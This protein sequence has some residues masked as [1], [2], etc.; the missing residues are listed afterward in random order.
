MNITKK[1]GKKCD[2]FEYFIVMVFKCYNSVDKEVLEESPQATVGSSHHVVKDI[3]GG[4]CLRSS[5]H[6]LFLQQHR[7]SR[8]R[9]HE[10]DSSATDTL[11]TLSG[12]ERI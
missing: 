4:L 5:A 7:L 2:I 9:Q 1:H 3:E 10:S 11:G 6:P 8:E 12:S